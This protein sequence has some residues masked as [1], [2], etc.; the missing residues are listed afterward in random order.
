LEKIS[1]TH[2]ITATKPQGVSTLIT[3][4]EDLFEDTVCCQINA[5]EFSAA[6]LSRAKTDATGVHNPETILLVDDHTL[7]G[8]Q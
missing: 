5:N 3:R 1:T 4:K 2:R 8:K 6:I 7:D